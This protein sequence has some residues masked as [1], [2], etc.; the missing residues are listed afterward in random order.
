MKIPLQIKKDITAIIWSEADAIN[1]LRLSDQEKSRQYEKWLVSDNVG[2]LMGHYLDQRNIR[3][4][5]K[6]SVIKPYSRERTKSLPAAFVAIGIIGPQNYKEEWIKPHGRILAD[7]RCIC[8]GP[9]NDWK[10]IILSVY[11]RS[12]RYP[13]AIPFAAALLGPLG[14]MAQTDEQNL[15]ACVARKLGLRKFYGTTLCKISICRLRVR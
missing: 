12:Y 1:W 15:V 11:E 13:Q 2:C 14:K 10:S 6:D 3:V 8:W 9:A 7:L 5:L 4:Y